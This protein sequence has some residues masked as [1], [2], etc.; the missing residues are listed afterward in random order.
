MKKVIILSFSVVLLLTISGCKKDYLNTSPSDAVT[1]ATIFSKIS[2]LYAAIDGSYKETFAFATGGGSHDD[3]GQ[4]GFDLAQDLMGNDMVVHSQGYGWFNTDY[5]FTETQRATAGRQSDFMW[6]YYYDLIK[7]ANILMA[8]LDG[9][10]DATQTDKEL[11]RG[12]CLAIRAYCMFYLINYYQQTY[13]GHESSPGV[14]VYVTEA[15]TGN[16]RGTVQQTYDQIV[17]DL[18]EAETLLDGKARASK[19][20]MDVSVVRGFRAR[21]ALIMNDWATAATAANAAKQGYTLMNN[22]NTPPSGYLATSAFSSIDNPEWMWGALITDE[23]ATIYASFFSHIDIRTGGYAALGGQKK[24]TKAL[25]DQIPD[26]DVRKARFRTPPGTTSNPAYNQ[27]KFQV[28]V[29]GSWA[30]DYVYMRA[31]EMYLIE[32]EALARQGQ[33]AAARTVLEALITTRDPAYSAASFSGSAL[34]DEILL[35][36]RIELWGEGFALMD[37]KRLNQGINR[38]TGD[39]NHGLPNYEAVVYVTGPADPRFLFRIPNREINV[40]ENMSLN[41]Q[42]P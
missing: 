17:A 30:A 26:G 42:N 15:L 32:A 29:A 3:F 27:L 2:G 36:R 14:P 11:V 39:G 8:V 18:T 9:V 7:Q 31:A 33:D 38:P 16:P 5:I 40:N 21:T 4:K 41:D 20:N 1:R 34:V 37:I 35:Q 23:E 22:T 12:Q 13:V 6:F 24:I 25:Y 19:V 10:P 28:P